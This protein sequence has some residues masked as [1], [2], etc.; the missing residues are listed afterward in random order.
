[1]RNKVIVA[2]LAVAVCATFIAGMWPAT[3]SGISAVTSATPMRTT[4]LVLTIG[5]AD[6]TVDGRMMTL[7]APPVILESRTLVPIRAVAEALGAI[8]S[9]DASTRTVTIVGQTAS[10]SLVIGSS[11]AQVNGVSVSIDPANT[12][13][14]PV[15]MSGRTMLPV[16]FVV[17]SLGAAVAY[18]AMMRRITITYSMP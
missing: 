7:D 3:T 2:L 17:E 14:V 5:S 1:M 18:D 6:M 13:V 16:R 15:I 11:N 12:K 4:V 9:W 10:L 8:V